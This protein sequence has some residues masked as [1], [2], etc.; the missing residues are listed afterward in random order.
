M[1][2]A[3]LN[4]TLTDALEQMLDELESHQLQVVLVPLNPSGRGYNEG[5]MKRVLADQNPKWY[6]TLCSQHPSSRGIR[7]GKHDTRIKRANILRA[8]RQMISGK[9]AGKYS[10]DLRRIA[11]TRIPPA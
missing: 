2:T 10:E 9:P 5:G 7:R 8:L 6:R 4:T 1:A 11:L 3:T